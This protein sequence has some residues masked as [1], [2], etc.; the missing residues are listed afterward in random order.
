MRARAPGAPLRP[1]VPPAGAAALPPTRARARA[2]AGGF[3]SVFARARSL[4]APAAA[5]ACT[6]SATDSGAPISVG[7]RAGTLPPGLVAF[8]ALSAVLGFAFVRKTSGNSALLSELEA[9]LGPG[10]RKFKRSVQLRYLRDE[11]AAG[12]GRQALRQMEQDEV[13]RNLLGRGFVINSET[14][15][16]RAF[17]AAKKRQAARRARFEQDTGKE[18]VDLNLQRLFL[19]PMVRVCGELC[20]L[21]WARVHSSDALAPPR[22]CR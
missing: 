14:A 2:S 9:E 19:P 17:K 7:A 18:V 15:D 11:V 1:P 8:M 20:R 12:R 5:I 10:V 16:P 21:Q 13:D 22:A 3:V 4:M 6:R